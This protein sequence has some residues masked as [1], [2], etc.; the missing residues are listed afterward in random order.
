[1]PQACLARDGVAIP[2]GTGTWQPAPLV[3][4]SQPSANT[5]AGPSVVAPM[6]NQADPVRTVAEQEGQPLAP[7]GAQP[8]HIGRY[9]VEKLLGKGGFGCIYR[10]RGRLRAAVA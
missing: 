3:C 9:R 8:S 4:Y 7:A 6:S 1:V 10:R 2:F 5:T